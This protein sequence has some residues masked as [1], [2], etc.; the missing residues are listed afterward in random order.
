MSA[1]LVRGGL[2]RVRVAD[3]LRKGGGS[4]RC[5]EEACSPET[6]G[7]WGKRG[8]GGWAFVPFLEARCEREKERGSPFAGALAWRTA[9]Q[10]HRRLSLWKLSGFPARNGAVEPPRVWS[11]LGAPRTIFWASKHRSGRMSLSQS[12]SELYQLMFETLLAE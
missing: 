8:G 9:P 10:T 2:C 1:F 5:K 11:Q 7:I 4:S 3:A 6:F 12:K